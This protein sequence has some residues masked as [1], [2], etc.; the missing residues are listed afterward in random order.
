[1]ANG[2]SAGRLTT[3]SDI[4]R[5]LRRYDDEPRGSQERAIYAQEPWSAESQAIISWSMPKGGLPEDAANLHL[6]RLIETRP[7][8]RL[9]MPEYDQLLSDGRLDE[10]CALLIARVRELVHKGDP[11]MFR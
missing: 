9:L 6:V 5:D 8:L 4:V 11:Y 3:L 10:L 1:L 7:A 2:L